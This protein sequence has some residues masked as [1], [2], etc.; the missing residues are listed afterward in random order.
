MFNT[1]RACCKTMLVRPAPGALSLEP[2]SWVECTR[3]REF[4]G[5]REG[6][7]SQSE[8]EMLLKRAPYRKTKT[9]KEGWSLG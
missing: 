1:N 8:G 7:D 6:G 4:D 9:K 2:V 5:M 3:G